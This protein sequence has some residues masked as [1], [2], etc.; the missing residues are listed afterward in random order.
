MLGL[1]DVRR[2]IAARERGKANLNWPCHGALTA[3]PHADGVPWLLTGQHKPKAQLSLSQAQ[4][5]SYGFYL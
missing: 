5:A 2:Y 4:G 1:S 3:L